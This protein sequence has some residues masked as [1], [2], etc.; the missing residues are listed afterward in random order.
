MLTL[1]QVRSK[2]A[3][4]LIGLHPIVAL[5]AYKLMDRCYR[6]GVPIVITQGLRSIEEQNKLY[7]QGRTTPGPIVTQAKGGYS[8]HNF[9]MAIDFALLLQDGKTVSWMLT[10]DG[11]SD[12]QS[13][14][15]EVVKEAKALGFHWGGDW[16]SFKDYPHLEMTFGLSTAQL[17]AGKSPLPANL[18][19]ILELL[20]K[21]EE[22][23]TKEDANLIISKFLR[24]AYS[25]AKT[26]EERAEIGRL[27]DAL[28][29]ASGQ[30]P[31]NNE[32]KG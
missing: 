16:K 4:R 6:R 21:G 12:G 18:D 5:A 10:R 27:A 31:Q 14:W 29:T 13:D 28:R 3:P 25:L 1:D 9:G 19:Q 7:A 8:N 2:S 26:N 22:T 15:V 24:P 17:R 32:S 23:M 30:A 20:R 11:D